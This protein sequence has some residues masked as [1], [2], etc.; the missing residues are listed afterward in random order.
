VVVACGLLGA[1]RL[2]TFGTGLVLGH[3]PDE[4]V[5]RLATGVLWTVGGVALAR[6]R[7]LGRRACYAAAVVT[8]GHNLYALWPFAG[9]FQRLDHEPPRAA[10]PAAAPV[11]DVVLADV[12]GIGRSE[13]LALLDVDVRLLSRVVC[14][15]RAARARRA[16]CARGEVPPHPLDRCAVARLETR[17]ELRA[18]QRREQRARPAAAHGEQRLRRVHHRV[19]EP[20]LPLLGGHAGHPAEDVDEERLGVDPRPEIESADVERVDEDLASLA[21]DALRKGLGPL[22]EI[23]LLGGHARSS[24]PTGNVSTPETRPSRRAP[25]RRSQGGTPRR[26]R[27]D[28]WRFTGCG[29]SM[30]QTWREIPGN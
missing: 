13:D 1:L 4:I 7:E 10:R 16:R 29:S 6:R 22:L 21:D 23:N 24:P 30:H 15:P 12:L 8:L 2:V 3:A 5:K 14:T 28:T 9:A 17:E 20:G 11:V 25:P 18:F 19:I 26:G 27:V